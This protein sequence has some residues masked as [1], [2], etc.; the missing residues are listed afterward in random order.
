[1][2]DHPTFLQ[3]IAGLAHDARWRFVCVG[4]GDAGYAEQ[5]RVQARELGLAEHL[6]WAGSCEDMVAAY[7]A[8][9]ILAS[10]S[11]GEGFPNVVARSEEHTSELQSLMPISYA[12]F[13]L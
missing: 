13:C 11:R 6:V 4:G 9:D 8:I 3:A 2:K 5:L 1:M 10:S 12:V 7:S